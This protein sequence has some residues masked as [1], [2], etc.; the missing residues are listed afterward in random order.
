[1]QIA[2]PEVY[3]FNLPNWSQPRNSDTELTPFE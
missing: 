1:M 2:F 3:I